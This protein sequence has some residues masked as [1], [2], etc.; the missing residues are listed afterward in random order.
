MWPAAGKKNALW[1]SLNSP[2]T[3]YVALR[4]P[5]QRPLNPPFDMR[6]TT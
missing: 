4:P 5:L 1:L 2:S 6:T 3:S